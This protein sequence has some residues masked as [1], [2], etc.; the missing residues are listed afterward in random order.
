MLTMQ[1]IIQ[2]IHKLLLKKQKTL[3]VAESCTG[4]LLSYLLTSLSGSSEYF[5]LGLVLYNNLAKSSLLGIPACL[6]EQKGT[7][8]G[9]I[10]VLFAERVM[11]LAK[12]DFGIG[13][14]GIAGPTG[15]KPNKPVGMVFIAVDSKKQKSCHKFHFSG[16]RSEI[17]KTAA[18]KAL[19]LLKPLIK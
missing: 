7:V 10:A 8:S 2:Q 13:I 1:L 9:P 18:L 12:T 11:K 3:A 5:V 14:T 17:R 15:A 19:Q 6:I 4:G 16:S